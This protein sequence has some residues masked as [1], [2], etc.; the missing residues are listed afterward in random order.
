M[1]VVKC[2][3]P[4]YNGKVGDGSKVRVTNHWNDDDK[5][6]LTIDGEVANSLSAEDLERLKSLGYL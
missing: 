5:V 4:T 1:I 2:E 3:I 6:M